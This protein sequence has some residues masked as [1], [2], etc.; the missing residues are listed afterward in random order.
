MTTRTTTKDDLRRL[1]DQLPESEFHAARRY[2]EYLRSMGAPLLRALQEA[3][4]DDEPTSPEEDAA[5]EAAWQE[6][7]RGEGIP[8]DQ[9]KRELS[10]LAVKGVARP[11]GKSSS[12]PGP[13]TTWTG[14]PP[15]SG[16][17]CSARWNG[18]LP[19][20]RATS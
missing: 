16:S 18:W 5:A 20:A 4:E 6:Y 19:R 1:V 7:L 15:W 9:V 10:A 13:V 12:L 2:L 3:P 11:R 17:A 14:C 8:L